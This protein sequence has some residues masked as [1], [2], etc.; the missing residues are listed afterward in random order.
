MVENS[1][2]KTPRG[3]VRGC[4]TPLAENGRLWFIIYESNDNLEDLN[5][6]FCYNRWPWNQNGRPLWLIVQPS[7]RILVLGSSMTYLVVPFSSFLFS[8]FSL[9]SS[10]WIFHAFLKCQTFYKIGQFEARS[11]PDGLDE[12]F[13][14]SERSTYFCYR[15]SLMIG[16]AWA[17]ARMSR[18]WHRMSTRMSAGMSSMMSAVTHILR[19]YPVWWS[20]Q[21][22]RVK[23][24]DLN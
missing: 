1:T 23:F 12:Q 3:E 19:D 10:T 22:F 21:G 9:I 14:L 24:M 13:V 11:G 4:G 18:L 16:T 2:T 20:F 8:L 7:P 5:G 15:H 17:I 6:K